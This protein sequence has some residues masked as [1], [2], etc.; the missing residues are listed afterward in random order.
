MMPAASL[1]LATASGGHAELVN[2]TSTQCTTKALVKPN[3]LAGSYL[4]NK[5]L[6]TG[7]C[8][9]SQMPKVGVSLT[10]VELD[11]IRA[12]ISTGALP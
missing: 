3:D 7:M 11:T 10:Q 4:M 5:L 2:V 6:G 9:G 1:S 12:W 8:Q